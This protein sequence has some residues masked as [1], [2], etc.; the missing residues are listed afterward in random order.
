MRLGIGA[1]D[2]MWP[3]KRRIL[4]RVLKAVAILRPRRFK[5]GE[6][7]HCFLGAPG[8]PAV[9]PIRR[10]G[11]L[12][13]ADFWKVR[14]D[15]GPYPFQAS[16]PPS[17]GEEH[18]RSYLSST[19][20]PS[21]SSLALSFS[22]SALGTPSLTALGA[23]STRSLASLRPRPVISRTALMTLI[24]LSPAADSTTLNSSLT[25]AGAA[26]AAPGAA[27]T[28]TG[29]AALTPH[30]SSKSLLS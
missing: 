16:S 22:A 21:A 15:K 4:L 11:P 29:A 7:T 13:R 6:N 10:R 18:E 1:T 30:F 27:A 24:F 9:R 12:V 20:A 2:S 28:A 26:A 3:K 14:S 8:P 17:G 23:A 25:S 19:L 5:G